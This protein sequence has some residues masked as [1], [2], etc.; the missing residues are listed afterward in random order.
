MIVLESSILSL[1]RLI[2]S[3]SKRLLLNRDSSQHDAVFQNDQE[4]IADMNSV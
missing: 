4:S 1:H 2:K 3:V